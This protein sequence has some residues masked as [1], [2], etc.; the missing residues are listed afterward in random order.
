MRLTATGLKI[1]TGNPT[2][3]LDVTGTATVDGLDIDTSTVSY[4]V[5]GQT[6]YKVLVSTS[7]ADTEEYEI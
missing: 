4:A 2:T 3:A 1:G 6:I 7:L 5:N